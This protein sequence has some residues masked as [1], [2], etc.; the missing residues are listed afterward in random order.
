MDTISNVVVGCK[1]VTIFRHCN[2][3]VLAILLIFLHFLDVCQLFQNK[4][5]LEKKDLNSLSSIKEF[6]IYEIVTRHK[7]SFWKTFEY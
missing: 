3:L 4:S 5:H 2:T 6:F 7:N 1:K